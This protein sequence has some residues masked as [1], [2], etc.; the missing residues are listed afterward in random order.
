MIISEPVNNQQSTVHNRNEIKRLSRI[1]N[2]IIWSYKPEINFNLGLFKEKQKKI[3]SYC[4]ERKKG[5]RDKR[6]KRKNNKSEHGLE[7]E[8]STEKK[9]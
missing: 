4:K 3:R 6:K 9:W 7:E 5:E 1:F 8:V 2:S